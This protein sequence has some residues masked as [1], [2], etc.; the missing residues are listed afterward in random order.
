MQKNGEVLAFDADGDLIG[1]IRGV[2]NPKGI[3]TGDGSV[4]VSSYFQGTLKITRIDPVALAVTGEWAIPALERDGS[5]VHAG[6]KLFLTKAN[7]TYDEVRS[8]DLA[9]GTFGPVVVPGT[10]TG[11]G[12]VGRDANRIM[13]VTAVGLRIFDVSGPS[14][15]LLASADGAAYRSLP[16]T[17]GP[18]DRLWTGDG[19]EHEPRRSRP[20]GRVLAGA[21]G[22]AFSPTFG[23]LFTRNG[24]IYAA[25]GTTMLHNVSNGH[26]GLSASGEVAFS[27]GTNELVVHDLRPHLGPGELS[28]WLP[29]DGD[30]FVVEGWRLRPTTSVTVDGVPAS[31]SYVGDTQLTV[32]VGLAPGPHTIVVTTPWGAATLAVTAYAVP[33]PP[34]VTSVSPSVV[35]L[36]GGPVRLTG[37]DFRFA[38]EVAFGGRALYGWEFTIVDDSTIEFVAPPRA[39]GSYAVSVEN[40]SGWS[41]PGSTLTYAEMGTISGTVRD[42]AGPLANMVVMVSPAASAGLVTAVVTAA[43]GSFSVPSL[44]VGSYKVYV[45]DGRLIFGVPA[46]RV[47]EWYQ[48]TGS[49]TTNFNAA[50]AVVVTAGSDRG[51]LRSSSPPRRRGRSPGW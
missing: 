44:P 46:E 39:A 35:P 14:L 13:V 8:F 45:F 50:S 15:T 22:A 32:D 19:R 34:T 41:P 17:D 37:T 31:T 49:G 27:F 36:S 9:T 20:T 3:T 16:T 25:D 12:Q 29:Y 5:L 24:A 38:Y 51:S 43:D 33:P 18:T 6:H 11:L 2:L 4:F 40:M 21:G 7:S 30:Y 23:G 47:A 10:V 48:A 1:R 42:T 28:D 26:I